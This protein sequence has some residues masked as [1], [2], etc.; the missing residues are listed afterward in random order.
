VLKPIHTKRF[1][2]HFL[3]DKNYIKRIIDAAAIQPSDC[4]IE[5]GPGG[6]ALT[7][8][9]LPLVQRLLVVEIDSKLCC[10]LKERFAGYGERFYLYHND[11]L[12]VDFSKLDYLHQ[13]PIRLI[14]NLPYNVATPILFHL[15]KYRHK[16]Y[17]WYV[18]VQKEVADRLVASP[19]SKAYSRLSVMMQYYCQIERL[20][21]VR[22]GA[23]L[24]PPK[25]EST[26]VKITPWKKQPFQANNEKLLAS[27]VKYAFNQ[28]RKQITNS[29]HAL[30]IQPEQFIE[31]QINPKARA[32]ELNVYDYVQLTNAWEKKSLLSSALLC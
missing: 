32:E 17:E 15:L 9:L 7:E 4:L 22:P 21:G 13:D 8:H 23:F 12:Q 14:G 19:K 2:Q 16:I 28:R 18:M 24:P 10:Y 6:G 1:G 11:A 30:G 29:L 26:V 31:C 3:H 27:V 20:F 5:I 25:V